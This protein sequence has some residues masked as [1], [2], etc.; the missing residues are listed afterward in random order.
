[1]ID[2]LADGLR[3]AGHKNLGYLI[4][5]CPPGGPPLLVLAVRYFFRRAVE[6]DPQLA[7]GLIFSKLEGLQ[8]AQK[9]GL[10]ALDRMLA[11]H[12]QRL[13]AAL[14]RFQETLAQTH[15]AVLDVQVE[16]QRQGQQ[17]QEIYQA[18]L[19]M[20]RLHDLQASVVR[21]R[22]SLS[23]RS[24]EDR[25]R[26]KT[27]IARY[28]ELPEEQQRKMPALTNDLGMLQMAAGDFAGAGQSFRRATALAP[29]PQAKGEGHLNAYRAALECG[30][31]GSALKE[32]LEAVKLDAQRF[33]TFPMGKYQPLRILGAGGFGVA[34]LCRH[35]L[36]GGQVVVKALTG[37]GLDR[38][39]EAVF[40]EAAHLQQLDHPGIIRV[41]D[42]GYTLPATKARP[43]V[44]MDYFEG[45]TLEE[46]AKHESL[47]VE[48]VLEVAR[49]IAEGLEA[50]H[51]RGILHSDIKPANVLVRREGGGWRVKLIDFGLAVRP[52]ALRNTVS[53]VSGLR[54]TVVGSSIAG[55]LEFAPPEQLG[56]LPGVAVRPY[57]DVYSFARTCCYALF[58]TPHPTGRHWG[59]IPKSLSDL[60]SECLEEEP[61]KRPQGFG[62]MKLRLISLD[63]SSRTEP[64]PNG[65]VARPDDDPAERPPVAVIPKVNSIGMR[66]AFIP[67]GRFLMGS[68]ETEFGRGADEGPQHEVILRHSF[69]MGAYP[70]TVAQFREFVRATPYH[71]RPE[72]TPRLALAMHVAE[73][74][75]ARQSGSGVDDKPA[76]PGMP[77]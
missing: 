73:G 19:E 5:L 17:L 4:A 35:R 59:Q 26:V 33:A 69:L 25:R 42:C 3:Q 15:G 32:L 40:A 55:T 30:D 1:V 21:P 9:Q 10:D 27:L 77:G 12:G 66:L 7:R 46:C 58:Q 68:P 72:M 45:Q 2:C 65:S 31:C 13:E 67:A 74:A 62:E 53:N 22:D 36:T 75:R 34:F 14:D 24:E 18:V 38:G 37:E 50:A 61:K 76:A 28:R 51:A 71:I 47:A 6:D 11:K 57:S 49:Q 8:Q 43:Y 29:D 41:Q 56:K 64:R 20:K 63:T 54:H 70:V 23:I 16:Q 52:Q 44:V 39:V 48:D 60:L